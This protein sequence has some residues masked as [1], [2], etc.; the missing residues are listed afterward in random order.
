MFSNVEKNDYV[1][2]AK[3]LEELLLFHTAK[4]LYFPMG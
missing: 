1:T 3:I 4:S 2:S